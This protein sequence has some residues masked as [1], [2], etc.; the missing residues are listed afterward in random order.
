L[1]PFLLRHYDAILCHFGGNG[2]DFIALRSVFPSTRFVTMFHGEDLR[3]GEEHGP[4]VF[5]TLK[6]VGDAFLVTTDCYGRET[7]RRYGF[8]DHKIYTH[9]LGIHANRI[10]FRERTL[11]SQEVRI[12]TVARLVP[13]KGLDLGIRAVAALQAAN[14]RICIQYDIIGDGPLRN[15]LQRLIHELGANRIVRLL[16]PKSSPDVL[17]SMERADLY[18]L[19]SR[20]EGAGVVL[21]E[22]QATGLP[23]VAARVGGVPEMVGAHRSALLVSPE[24]TDGFAAALQQLLDHSERWPLM[25]REGRAHVEANHNIDVL[26]DR[27]VQILRG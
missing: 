8:P 20:M 15:D 6:A 1:Q 10:S 11:R 2:I 4:E 27:L 9:R 23:V 3:I 22:A 7:L 13:T 21:L 25:G 14:P 12:L 18:L 24:D 26:N 17:E 5:S 16:G 19:P